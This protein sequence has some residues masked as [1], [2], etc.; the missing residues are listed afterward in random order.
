M[1][2]VETGIK[3]RTGIVIRIWMRISMRIRIG[4]GT[5]ICLG[6]MMG[7]RIRMFK[8]EIGLGSRLEWVFG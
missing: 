6:K 4:T 3:I 1:M 8:M 2:K 7:I 5:G